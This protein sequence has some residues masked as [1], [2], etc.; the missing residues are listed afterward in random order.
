MNLA[1]DLG[2][3]IGSA[4]RT[5]DSVV[6]S[7]AQNFRSGRFDG[8]GMPFLSFCGWLLEQEAT[9]GPVGVV[10]FEEV[11]LHAGV[12]AAHVY[13]EV[14]A[15]LTAGCVAEATSYTRVQVG[16]IKR[17]ATGKGNTG[18]AAVMPA[19]RAAGHQPGGDNEADALAL[20]HWAMAQ[21]ELASGGRR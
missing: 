5:L 2:T 16:T 17:H 13:G 9:A 19:M 6:A 1:L 10:V 20:L 15:T 8:G 14:M 21:P 11:R 12:E 18:K 7:G 4:V 3:S